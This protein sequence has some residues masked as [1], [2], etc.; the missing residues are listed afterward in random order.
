M[1]EWISV[2]ERL[3]ESGEYVLVWC[4]NVQVARI[5]KGIS[6]TE[7]KAM[8]AGVLDDPAEPGWCASEG[9][10]SH[11]RSNLFRECDEWGNNLVPYHWYANG[12]PMSWF[13]QDVTHWMPLPEPP[14][15]I[16]ELATTTATVSETERVRCADCKHILFSDCYGECSAGHRG[17]VLPDDTC[18]HGERRGDHE[19]VH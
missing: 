6:M 4:G 13:G 14:V 11:K 15:D 17:I 9:W 10:R 5:E 2:K 19:G 8:Q 1:S 7:R 18:P 16:A 12:G 3:P